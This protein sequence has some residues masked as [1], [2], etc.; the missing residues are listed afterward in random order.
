MFCSITLFNYK[1][2]QGFG[3]PA[4]GAKRQAVGSTRLFSSTRHAFE[5]PICRT[6]STKPAATPVILS[7]VAVRAAVVFAFGVAG[8]VVASLFLCSMPKIA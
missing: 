2:E 4:S 7:L 3:F 1:V 8:V 6:V 5:A